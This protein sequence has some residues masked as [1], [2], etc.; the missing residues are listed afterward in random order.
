MAHL[1]FAPS[2]GREAAEEIADGLART[3]VH[4]EAE[5]ASKDADAAEC[6]VGG[7]GLERMVFKLGDV[8]TEIGE[9]AALLHACRDELV[10][11]EAGLHGVSRILFVWLPDP[12]AIRD[13]DEGE[14]V[15]AEPVTERGEEGVR[16]QDALGDEGVA[17]L[18]S[19]SGGAD[20]AV[21]EL[22]G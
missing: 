7:G 10:E 20:E 4:G 14:D 3:D 19:V 9:P 16:R 5:G 21:G 6:T 8:A 13:T 2:F 17:Q 11:V 22:L 18:A 15:F 12:D 1:E